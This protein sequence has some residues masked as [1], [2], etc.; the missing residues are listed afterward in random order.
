MSLAPDRTP[1]TF[2]MAPS[3]PKYIIL[4]RTDNGAVEVSHK[5]KSG[6][7]LVK[8][9]NIFFKPRNLLK[10]KLS[11]IS[12]YVPKNINHLIPTKKLSTLPTVP[13]VVRLDENEIL[14]ELKSH[15]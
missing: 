12:P 7:L 15:L 1:L 4:T 2:N 14:E 5:T 6:M 9:L 10:Y 8:K 11:I 13:K 3:E